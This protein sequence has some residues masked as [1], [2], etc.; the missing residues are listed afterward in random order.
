[1]IGELV[2]DDLEQS[3][4]S[5]DAVA[6]MGEAPAKA[7]GDLAHDVLLGTS[8]LG[9]TE[10]EFL[11]IDRWNPDDNLD[12]FYANPD[13]QMA[14]GA[15]F[16][17]PP[18]FAQYVHQEAWAQ[19]GDMDIVDGIEPHHFVV[20]RGRL[21]SA[22]LAAMQ[23]LHDQVALGGKDAAMA[24]GDLGHVAFL[25]RQD[26][27]E[28]LAIDLWGAADNIEALYTNPDFMMAFGQLFEGAPKIGVYAST[29]W[30]QW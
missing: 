27:Q 25:G 18:T 2:G 11:A 13:F 7:A 10:N 29:D 1:V 17:G 24:L 5:H 21:K 3:Q 22:D 4:A 8:L 9:T 16:A 28:F 20:V 26:P 23:M 30:H 15:L 14:F 19:W 12:A 6:M